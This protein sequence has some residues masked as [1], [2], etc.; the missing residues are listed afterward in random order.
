M[1]TYSYL[2]LPLLLFYSNLV[3]FI[4][5][6]KNHKNVINPHFFDK[7]FKTVFF[8]KYVPRV[9]CKLPT[10]E[11]CVLIEKVFKMVSLKVPSK[12]NKKGMGVTWGL[13]SG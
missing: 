12:Q 13:A 6:I 11:K 10:D 2:T 1:G 5:N 3:I 7:A 4:T 9:R 8:T